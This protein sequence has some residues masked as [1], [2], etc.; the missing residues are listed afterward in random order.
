MKILSVRSLTFKTTNIQLITIALFNPSSLKHF[1][2]KL[3]EFIYT[4]PITASLPH[5]Q[6]LWLPVKLITFK[7]TKK[8]HWAGILS[9]WHTKCQI[10]IER[11]AAAP[12]LRQQR[13]HQCWDHLKKHGGKAGRISSRTGITW[14]FIFD[15]GT[16]DH[17]RTSIL[18]AP[19]RWAGPALFT[20]SQ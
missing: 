20:A 16:E 6:F 15:G 17:L 13:S 9:C 14:W 3:K 4:F 1:T 7:L 19:Q 5:N 18:T 12:Q 10:P 11:A 8:T 2:F